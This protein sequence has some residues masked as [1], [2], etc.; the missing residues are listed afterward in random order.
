MRVVSTDTTLISFT[1]PK[2]NVL[3]LQKIV[4]T[5]YHTYILHIWSI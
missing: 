3:I 4:Y 2:K 1:C 5:S